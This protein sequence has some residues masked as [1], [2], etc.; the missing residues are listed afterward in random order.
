MFFFQRNS[1]SLI[2]IT[3][4][5]FFSVMHVCVDLKN[6]VEKDSSTTLL[7]FFPSKGLAGHAIS[8][9]KHLELLAVVSNLLIELFYIGMP[10]VRM[11]GRSDGRTVT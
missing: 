5:S 9:Q 7:L 11:D 3:R 8:H 6:D 2:L 4:S 10:V 1:S